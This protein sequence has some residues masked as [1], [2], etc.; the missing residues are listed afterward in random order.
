MKKYAAM[1][2]MT[3]C[4]W[5]TAALAETWTLRQCLDYALDNNITI[6][7]N[8]IAENTSESSLAQYKSQLWPSLNFS[9]AQNVAYRPL[10]RDTE[11][12]T[13][14]GQVVG[15]SNK[16]TGSSNYNLSMNWTI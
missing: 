6:N 1:M 9:T 8:R 2:L 4:A 5:N 7:K 10:Q 3:L 15:S 11:I 13:V 16:V 12:R 14:D